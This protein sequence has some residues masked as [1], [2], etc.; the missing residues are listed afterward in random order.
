MVTTP[1]KT[2]ARTSIARTTARS[3][4]VIRRTSHATIVGTEI[5]QKLWLTHLKLGD[6]TTIEG[7]ADNIESVYSFFRSIK[8]Y[9]P[10]SDITLQEL[11]LAS[12]N[13]KFFDDSEDETPNILTSLNADFYKFRISN[14][15]APANTENSEENTNSKKTNNKT[16]EQALPELEVINQ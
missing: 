15:V 14:E 1:M 8:D 3:R 7:Q 16:P 4:T 2:P 6:K 11:G 10:K 12:A 9:N 13:P 5:P